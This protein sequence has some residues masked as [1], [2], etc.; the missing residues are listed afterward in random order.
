M[1]L[2]IKNIKG[3]F[4]RNIIQSF[5]LISITKL[6]CILQIQR[7][8]YINTSINLK[9]LRIGHLLYR[10]Q[11]VLYYVSQTLIIFRYFILSILFL[12]VISDFI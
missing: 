1:D 3:N 2:R 6:K 8:K 9:Y 5:T 11:Y 4:K 10:K 12:E 7:K